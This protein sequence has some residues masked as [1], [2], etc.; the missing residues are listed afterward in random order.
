MIEQQHL[1]RLEQ[2]LDRGFAETQAQLQAW[3]SRIA[4][5]VLTVLRAI[6]SEAKHG[7]RLFTIQPLEGNWR[8][9]FTKRYRLHLWC[10][11]ENCQHPVYQ[12]G[13][14]IY[15]FETSRE[16]LQRLAPY[17]NL[18][19]QMLKTVAPIAIPAAHL[20]LGN[21][22]NDLPTL[23]Q[24]LK[25]VEELTDS[26]LEGNLAIA[27]TSHLPSGCLSEAERSGILALHS[28]LRDRDPHQQNLGLT[29]IVTASGEYRWLCQTHFQAQQPKIPE[30]ST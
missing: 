17:A 1:H 21:A 28:F 12:P 9:I 16:W 29:R 6:A 5:Y 20:I 2:K 15:D 10:E 3:E 22:A 11:A 13:K 25:L 14:G 30:T 24:Q 7:P 8:Q 19:A 18:V 27:A 26:L 23:L 4:N